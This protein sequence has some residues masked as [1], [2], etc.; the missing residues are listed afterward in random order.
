MLG[1]EGE[2]R[3][4]FS[5]GARLNSAAAGS[6]V[7]FPRQRGQPHARG[8]SARD[9]SCK[10]EREGSGPV[11]SSREGPTVFSVEVEKQVLSV[12][13]GPHCSNV[14][15]PLLTKLESGLASA[16]PPFCRDASVSWCGGG[17]MEQEQCKHGALGDNQATV[18][19]TTPHGLF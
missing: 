3:P 7:P 15:L 9:H 1:E 5:D 10:S 16:V 13:L 19:P 6:Q 4:D 2:G 8:D 14:M 11:F 17:L 18:Q 12:G